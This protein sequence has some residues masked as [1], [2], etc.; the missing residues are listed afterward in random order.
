VNNKARKKRKI[1][2]TKSNAGKRQPAVRKKKRGRFYHERVSGLA[3][4]Y[5]DGYWKKFP[6]L[7][8]INKQ[9]P[10]KLLRTKNLKQTGF[11]SFL[12]RH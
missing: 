1:T 10:L 5:P 8:F 9:R 11:V 2:A 7:Q 3:L 6:P 4:K 12:F